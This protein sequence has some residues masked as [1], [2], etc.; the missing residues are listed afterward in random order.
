MKLLCH[1]W[2][3]AWICAVLSGLETSTAGAACTT[4]AAAAGSSVG[5]V[6]PGPTVGLCCSPYDL[7]P[8]M[9]RG[10]ACVGIEHKQKLWMYKYVNTTEYHA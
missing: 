5:D 2:P 4:G 9:Q 1:F 6:L 10:L 8:G 3:P 7:L